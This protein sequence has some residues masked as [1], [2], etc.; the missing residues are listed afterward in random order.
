[1][2]FSKELILP[3]DNLSLNE[4]CIEING[5]KSIGDKKSWMHAI[6]DAMCEKYKFSMDTPFKD[7]P[8]EIKDLLWNGNGLGAAVV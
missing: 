7:Y 3:N 2:E 5:L 1:M 6:M 8:Q 4:G